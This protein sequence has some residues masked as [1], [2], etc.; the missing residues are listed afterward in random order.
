MRVH[1]DQHRFEPP[2]H[3]IGAPVLRE[4]DRGSLEV[5]A[6]LFEL[7]FE[8]RKE[9][10]RIGGRSGKPREN[11]V[12]VEAANLPRALFDDGVAEGDLPVAGHY[13]MIAVAHGQH[14]CRVKHHQ[15]G[16]NDDLLRSLSNPP[17]SGGRDPDGLRPAGP[18]KPRRR[19]GFRAATGS[20]GVL[21]RER[22]GMLSSEYR[23]SLGARNNRR[24]LAS[25]RWQICCTIRGGVSCKERIMKPFQSR[26]GITVVGLAL[27]AGPALAGQRPSQDSGGGHG[28]ARSGR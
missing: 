1:D 14:C 28:G 19:N 9:R 17:S 23:P 4:L 12:V 15:E 5:T 13:G 8:A 21:T 7:G 6:I 27:L 3:P 16:R 22:D 24:F 25:A 10:K 26:L 20:D 2:E 18:C 11:P